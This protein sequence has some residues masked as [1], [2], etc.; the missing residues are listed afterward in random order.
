MIVEAEAGEF[1]DA[2]LFAENARGVVVLKDPVVETRF[3]TATAVEQGI[4][5]GVKESLG[6]GEQ[7]FAG[8]KEL[9]LVAEVFGGTRAGKFGGLEFAGGA[10]DEGEANRGAGRMLR[11]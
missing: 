4:F 5:C 11:Y 2:E 1:G 9:Q 7:R 3:D 8:A 6:A 10:I